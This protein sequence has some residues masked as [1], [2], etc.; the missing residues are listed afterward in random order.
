MELMRRKG[1]V[2]ASSQKQSHNTDPPGS[3]GHRK[4]KCLLA[5]SSL[6]A[7][8]PLEE[9]MNLTVGQ[10]PGGSHHPIMF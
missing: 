6:P 1:A 2:P 7:I 5:G 3:A 10:K 9:V 8:L 4:E